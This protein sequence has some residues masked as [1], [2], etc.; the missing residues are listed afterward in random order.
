LKVRKSLARE[1]L[2]DTRH[3]AIDHVALVITPFP[4]LATD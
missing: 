4:Q 1:I 2:R 3:V